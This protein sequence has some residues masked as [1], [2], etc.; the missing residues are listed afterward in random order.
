RGERIERA[1]VADLLDLRAPPK[2]FDG[3]VRG[4][5]ALFVEQKEAVYGW[6]VRLQAARSLP[7]G[8]ATLRR[9]AGW[10]AAACAG[11]PSSAERRSES[12]ARPGQPCRRAARACA[13]GRAIRRTSRRG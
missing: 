10:P 6:F 9:R 3:I 4:D 12:A 11:V 13:A 2:L 8:A 1:G 7:C 5:A